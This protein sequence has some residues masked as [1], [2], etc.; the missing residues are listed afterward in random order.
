MTDRPGRLA[1][2]AVAAT[3]VAL[4]LATPAAA[5]GR[6]V[7][8][9]SSGG[10]EG[11]G[12][13]RVRFDGLTAVKEEQ[14]LTVPG[15]T[16]LKLHAPAASGL[17]VSGW[18]RPD[19]EV[20]ACKA[21]RDATALSGI[22]VSAPNGVVSVE[23]IDDE[24]ALILFY[25]RVPKGAVLDLAAENG[26]MSLRDLVGTVTARLV[27]GPLSLTSVHGTVDVEAEN[28]PV[29]F[30]GGSGDW[31][32]SVTNGPLSAKLTGARWEGKGL[33]AETVNGPLTVRLDPRFDSGLR[34]SAASH[35][36]FRCRA[37]ACADA[38]RTAESEEDGDQILEIGS[39]EPLV[40]LSTVNGPVTIKDDVP[41]SD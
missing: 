39:G 22:S 27:N 10:D 30:R 19:F 29:S 25:V 24:R 16:P 11:C 7:S 32:L 37:A 21:A 41:D 8:I 4:T 35:A 5:R 20:T 13:L 17:H 6:D 36:P 34:V 40:R 3:T 12:S 31:T 2:L 14:T 15:R 18:D 23:G 9:D 38:R 1:L 28:G 33:V 26:P